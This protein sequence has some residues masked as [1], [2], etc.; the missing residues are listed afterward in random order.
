M[1]LGALWNKELL[2]LAFESL[3]FEWNETF[4]LA[5]I[6]FEPGPLCVMMSFSWCA[7]LLL[8]LI[9]TAVRMFRVQIASEREN[10]GRLAGAQ[11]VILLSQFLMMFFKFQF[12]L[13]PI[14][15][16]LSI[17]AIIISVH[18]NEFWGIMEL[19]HEWV[20]DQMEDAFVIVDEMYGYLESNS[21]AK[22]IFS[23][24]NSKQK[25]EAVP[26]ELYEIFTSSEKIIRIQG[27]Y[28]TKKVME[29]KEKDKIS[30]YSLFLV[31]DTEQYELMERVREEKERADAANQAKSAFVSNVSHEIRTPMN[32]IVG[33]T[34]I[35]LRRDLP[36][37]EHEYLL[38]IQNSGNALKAVW[39]CI[40]HPTDH[41]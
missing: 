31:D 2:H 28:Y 36:K 17:L 4:G 40:A 1:F 30:G 11:F 32:A 18:R 37:Q 6:Q 5:L 3:Q 8:G 7:T 21:Y 29:L 13:V 14:C 16:T 24:L 35:M 33:M 22:K 15:N 26:E 23:E 10:L 20:F 12:D 39:R 9:Y 34:Q 41:H 19:G 25:N 27:R 38:N